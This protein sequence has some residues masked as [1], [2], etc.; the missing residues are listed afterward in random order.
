MK[1]CDIEN[2][3]FAGGGLKGFIHIGAL[4]VLEENSIL[5]KCKRFCGASIGYFFALLLCIGIRVVDIER[6]FL[7]I[8]PKQIVSYHPENLV[9]LLN[10]CHSLYALSIGFLKTKIIF[11]YGLI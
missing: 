7:C 2:L 10:I 8:D 3:V 6:L 9:K 1:E 11:T 5:T 4:Q